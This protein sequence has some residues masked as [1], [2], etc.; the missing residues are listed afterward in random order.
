MWLLVKYS[1]CAIISAFT[2]PV[3]SLGWLLSSIPMSTDRVTSSD[4]REIWTCTQSKLWSRTKP[5]YERSLS[6]DP[7]NA[8][9]RIR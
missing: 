7:V 3:S 5:G 4:K 1:L 8:W 6:Y 9:P 2:T